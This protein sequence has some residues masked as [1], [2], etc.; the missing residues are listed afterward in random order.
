[1][2]DKNIFIKTLIEKAKKLP[3]GHYLDIRSYKRN[4]TVLLIKEEDDLFL[5]IEDG[6]FR[7]EFRVNLAKLKK[8]F[9]V[10]LKKEFP[11]SHKIRIY[12]MGEYT[13][14]IAKSIKR[15]KL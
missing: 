14:T 3:I 6:F 2:I 4:R 7:E 15:K 10:I 11:R 5:V 12:T 8:L 13:E 1:M 9:K